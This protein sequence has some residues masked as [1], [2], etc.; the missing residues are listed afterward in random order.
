[1]VD[2]V[3]RHILAND[4]HTLVPSGVRDMSFCS[5]SAERKE[6]TRGEQ[7][8]KINAK[9]Q[10]TTAPHTEIM[11]QRKRGAQALQRRRREKVKVDHVLGQGNVRAA[12]AASTAVAQHCSRT[13][14]SRAAVPPPPHHHRHQNLP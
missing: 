14:Q 2:G 9:R 5:A 6:T 8:G 1:M 4:K 13:L 12:H 10:A 3:H 11:E 7:A